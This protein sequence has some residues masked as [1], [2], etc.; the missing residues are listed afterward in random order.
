[1]IVAIAALVAIVW[2]NTF[3]ESYFRFAETFA[4]AVNDIGMAFF[5]ALI[6]KEVVEAT[7]P[8]GALHTW[9]RLMLPVVAGVGGVIGAGLAYMAYLQLGDE[10]SVLG[11]GWTVACATDV[12]FS[13]FVARSIGK[14]YP[15]IP[16]IL[17]LGIS[18]DVLSLVVVELGYPLAGVHVSRIL[19]VAI[20]V[21]CCYGLRRLRIRSFW[22]YLIVGGTASW[23]GLFW[24]GFDP[25]L[26][27]VPIVP[28]LPHAA[29]DPG[30]FVETP[31]GHRDALSKFEYTWKHPVSVV[32]FL[33]GLVNGGV[34]IRGF[35]TGTWSVLTAALV[36]K[37]LGIL[38]AIGLAL[39][40]GLRLPHRLGW[41]D[42]TVAAVIAST[43]FTFS[44]F[45]ATAVFPL[46]PVL[47]E[48]KMGALL[49]IC[50]ALIAIGAA[51][52]LRVGRFAVPKEPAAPVVPSGSHPR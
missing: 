5:F 18:I 4:F 33:F 22:P 43:G 27:L 16:F 2:A 47:I 20:G 8:G 28:F 40:A 42:A 24:G 45:L 51:A 34:L 1:M 31:P 9:R 41:R 15:A 10:M 3:A 36:G 35:G 12:S 37:P 14:R 49:T 46:G 32:L 29:R 19:L 38:A 6:T 50:G 7:L 13:Y 21:A 25:A 23:L 11:A 39:L 52:W 30:F 26:A 17:L 48:V 44:L